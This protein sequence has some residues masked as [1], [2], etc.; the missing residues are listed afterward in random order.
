MDLDIDWNV[1]IKKEARGID[2]DDL[3]EIQGITETNIITKVGRVD[4]ET[5]SIPKRLADKFDGHKVWFRITKE[6]AKSQYKI[7]E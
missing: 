3:G 7:D 4:K 1:T 2:D 5:Y 6:E